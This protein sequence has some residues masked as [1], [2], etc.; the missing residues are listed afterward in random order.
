[1]YTCTAM[2]RY[3]YPLYMSDLC[4]VSKSVANPLSSTLMYMYTYSVHVYILGYS[5]SDVS[6]YL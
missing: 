2:M 3:I 6:L 1:M 4:D 5:V